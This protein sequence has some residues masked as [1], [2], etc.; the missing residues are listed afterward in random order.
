MEEYMQEDQPMNEIICKRVG[1][2]F[3]KRQL[4]FS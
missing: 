4:L 3:H 1:E 2:D